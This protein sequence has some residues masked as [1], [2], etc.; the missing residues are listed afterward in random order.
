MLADGCDFRTI[1][2]DEILWDYLVFEIKDDKVKEKLLWESGLTVHKTF[3]ICQAD[4]SMGAQMKFVSD[5][6]RQQL[7]Q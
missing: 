1:T 2:P 6:L 3:E 5:N 4:E 7:M